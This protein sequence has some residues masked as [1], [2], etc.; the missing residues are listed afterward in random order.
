MDKI[1]LEHL[2]FYAYHGCFEEEKEQGQTFFVSATLEL[3]LTLAGISDDLKHTVNYG[4]VYD[5]IADITLNNKF[6]LIE[7]LAYAII[8]GLL[9]EFEQVKAVTVRVDKPKAPGTTCKFP[10]TVELRRER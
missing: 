9:A 4:E 6:D 8:T 10:A 5:I 1:M 3:D 2:E 7:K